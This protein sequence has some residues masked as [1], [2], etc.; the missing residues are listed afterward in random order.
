MSIPASIY[1]INNISNNYDIIKANSLQTVNEFG[2]VYLNGIGQ[3]VFDKSLGKPK[4]WTGS[5]WVDATGADV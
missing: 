1:A 2:T 3:S 5:K 4:W